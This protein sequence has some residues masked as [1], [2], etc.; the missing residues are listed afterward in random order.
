MNWHQCHEILG[1]GV[2]LV[3]ISGYP[4]RP[5]HREGEVPVLG[6]LSPKT[7]N[8]SPQCH[9]GSKAVRGRDVAESP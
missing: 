1:R 4:N 3:E 5:L 2:L 8:P 9:R 6:R 7:K